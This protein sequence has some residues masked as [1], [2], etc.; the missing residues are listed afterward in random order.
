MVLQWR[1]GEGYEK[2]KKVVKESKCMF[3]N[4]RSVMNNEKLYIKLNNS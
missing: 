1:E 4:I 3:T 2:G